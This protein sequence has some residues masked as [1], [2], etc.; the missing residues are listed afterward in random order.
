MQLVNRYADAVCRAK[1]SSAARRDA[2]CILH[3]YS[4]AAQGIVSVFQRLVVLMSQL[5]AIIDR[6]SVISDQ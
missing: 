4:A 2:S 5:G 3:L 6:G 1:V